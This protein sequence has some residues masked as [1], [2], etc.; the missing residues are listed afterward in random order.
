MPCGARIELCNR[1]AWASPPPPPHTPTPAPVPFLN[2]IQDQRGGGKVW[3]KSGDDA[4]TI[5]RRGGARGPKKRR[6][7]PPALCLDPPPPPQPPPFPSPAFNAAA[8]LLIDARLKTGGQGGARFFFGGT[9]FWLRAPLARPPPP[10]LP[11]APTRLTS[12]HP[13]P[14]ASRPEACI[15]CRRAARA[16]CRGNGDR[17]PLLRSLKKT[18]RSVGPGQK[19]F[20]FPPPPPPSIPHPLPPT[21]PT[22]SGRPPARAHP[23]ASPARGLGP[24]RALKQE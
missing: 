1:S 19:R 15:P 9:P 3:A 5:G 4:P 24:A 13:L 14:P 20:S 7:A 16:A 6:R 11:P 17:P 22:H 18:E 10:P 12:R 2:A 21:R 8:V 23:R